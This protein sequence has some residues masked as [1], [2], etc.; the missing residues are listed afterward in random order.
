TSIAATRLM[1]QRSLNVHVTLRQTLRCLG[2][3]QQ[4][5]DA[6]IHLPSRRTPIRWLG[7][8]QHLSTSRMKPHT[9]TH[10]HAQEQKESERTKA[11]AARETKRARHNR[12]QEIP[13]GDAD[14]RRIW[15]QQT[16]LKGGSPPGK[17]TT[18]S[19]QNRSKTTNVIY[20]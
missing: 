7:S 1:H 11:A 20:F 16:E 18:R 8:A 12:A 13:A 17:N 3:P 15:K 9:H 19:Q 6:Q 5:T 14:K 2:L 10:T 4:L